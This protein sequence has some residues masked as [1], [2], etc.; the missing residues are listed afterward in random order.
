[1]RVHY[2][3]LSLLSPLGLL[4]CVHITTRVAFTDH[5]DKKKNSPLRCSYLLAVQDTRLWPSPGHPAVIPGIHRRPASTPCPQG[6]RRASHRWCRVE[7]SKAMS[8]QWSL[9]D[10]VQL[11]IAARCYSGGQ[12]STSV[13]LP[14][15]LLAVV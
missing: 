3:I 13:N 8:T 1:M 7:S 2:A 9:E 4:K 15:F 10:S 12:T 5:Y 14:W 6:A 11:G